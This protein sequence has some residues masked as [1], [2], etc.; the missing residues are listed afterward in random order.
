MGSKATTGNVPDLLTALCGTAVVCRG[1]RW[2]WVI[3][4]AR[5]FPL[6]RTG[7]RNG[8]VRVQEDVVLC[9]VLEVVQVQVKGWRIRPFEHLRERKQPQ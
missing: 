7:S 9:T 4:R 8:S 2:K 1:P 6:V 3:D 5:D